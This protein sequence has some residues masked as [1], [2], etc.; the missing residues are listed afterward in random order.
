MMLVLDTNVISELMKVEPDPQVIGWLDSQST[1]SV[2]T[3]SVS[4][5]EISFGLNSSPDGKRK[6]ALKDA[7]EAMLAEEL[8]QCVGH[9][10][11]VRSGQARAGQSDSKKSFT[12]LG[13]IPLPFDYR[14]HSS[15]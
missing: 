9:Q 14:S 15:R 4:V 11:S 3:T 8:E 12:W 10:N 1:G 13:T 7:F 2:W 5:F 6:R